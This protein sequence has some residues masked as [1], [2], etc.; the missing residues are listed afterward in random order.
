MSRVRNGIFGALAVSLTLGAMQLAF[1]PDLVRAEQVGAN[2][3]PR[4]AIN[5]AAKADRADVPALPL[6]TRTI[7]LRFDGLSDMTVLLRVDLGGAARPNVPA[8]TKP[9]TTTVACEPVVSVLTDL[10]KRL[11]PGR[12][13]T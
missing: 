8:L 10:A 13:I 6:P 12:C 3:A 1:G 4:A 5:R 11:Q 9:G 7:A 2:D